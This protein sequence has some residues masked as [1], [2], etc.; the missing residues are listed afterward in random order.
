MHE[1]ERRQGT[2][3]SFDEH[4]GLGEVVEQDGTAYLFHCV[5]IADG[6]RTI[7]IGAAVEFTRVTRFGRYE[8]TDLVTR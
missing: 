3:R 2:V 6:T 1:T 7:G 5:G 8:A 4:V